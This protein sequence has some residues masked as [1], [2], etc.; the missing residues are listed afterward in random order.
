MATDWETTEKDDQQGDGDDQ[1]A[2]DAAQESAGN[3]AIADKVKATGVTTDELISRAARDVQTQRDSSQSDDSKVQ[4]DPDE[5][6]TKKDIAHIQ[7]DARQ[8]A[9]LE[10][11]TETNKQKIAA[12]IDAVTKSSAGLGSKI[13]QRKLM[14]VQQAVSV[15]LKKNMNLATLSDEQFYT[16]ID[17]ITKEVVAEE[18]E[19]ARSIV[20]ANEDEEMTSRLKA[21]RDATNSGSTG[22]V[23]KPSTTGGKSQADSSGENIDPDNPK[24]GIGTDWPTVDEAD[25][26]RDQEMDEFHRSAASGR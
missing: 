25:R 16:E 19:D 7:E 21:Q 24:Y 18:K 6:L 2:K 12:R 22:G 17:R 13:P 9:R 14:Q 10:M 20:G 1:A 5:P 26:I 23:S 11:N 15:E 4:Q 3:K 8:V